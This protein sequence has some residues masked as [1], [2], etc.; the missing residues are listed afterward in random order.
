M[1]GGTVGGAD[2]APDGDGKAAGDSVAGDG[3]I[4]GGMAVAIVDGGEPGD[5]NRI[6]DNA[7]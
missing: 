3:A 7:A 6:G 5:S 2:E 4:D 1:R